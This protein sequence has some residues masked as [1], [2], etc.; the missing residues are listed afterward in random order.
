MTDAVRISKALSLWLRH[1]PEKA[2]LRLSDDGWAP[3]DAVLAALARARL[4][5]DFETL[6]DVVERNDK[7]RFEFSADLECIRARQGHSVKVALGLAPCAPPDMLY[8]GTV[9][10]F[11]EPIFAQGLLRMRRTH[12]HLSPDEETA[13]KVGARRGAPVILTIDARAMH[14]EG[15]VFC[16]SGNGVW[17]TEHVPPR[18]LNRR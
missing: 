16:V 13:L 8:H 10:R 4:A 1:A 15:H 5:Q 2:A 18:Y 11:L 6:L 17:L 7:Q 3:V 9:A 12:V 14:A